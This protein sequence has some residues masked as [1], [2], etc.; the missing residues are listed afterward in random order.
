MTPTTWIPRYRDAVPVHFVADPT[1][2]LVACGRREEGVGDARTEITYGDVSCA[3]CRS[4]LPRCCDACP[5]YFAEDDSNDGIA[6]AVQRCDDCGI[7]HG[8]EDAARQYAVERFDGL[9]YVVTAWRDAVH[10]AT[11]SD[12]VHV[13]AN[14]AQ[15]F[16]YAGELLAKYVEPPMLPGTLPGT[17]A[18][19]E[20]PYCIEVRVERVSDSIRVVPA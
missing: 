15:A 17:P 8:D 19:P 12:S 2:G 5:G 6:Y 4:H 3:V 13:F 20:A 10:L 16:V 14:P 11:G 18:L 1:T 9:G 7:F